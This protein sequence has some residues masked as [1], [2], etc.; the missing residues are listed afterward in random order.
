[1]TTNLGIFYYTIHRSGPGAFGWTACTEADSGNIN[2]CGTGNIIHC[3]QCSHSLPYRWTGRYLPDIGLYDTA[4]ISTMKQHFQWM[5]D[6]G[7]GFV[8]FSWWGKNSISDTALNTLISAIPGFNLEFCIYYENE[9][10]GNP[11]INADI[12]YLSNKCFNNSQ[13]LKVDVNGTKKPVVWVYNQPLASDAQR[14]IATRNS[15]NIY[16]VLKEVPNWQT[17]TGIDAWHQYAPAS[18]YGITK[19]TANK[20]SSFVSPGFYRYHACQR[21]AR[22]DL[23]NSWQDFE[24]ALLTMKND[25]AQWHTIQTFNEWMECSGVEP[26]SYY[27]HT[28][29]G[30]FPK[31]NN[32][33]GTKYLDLI[34]KYFASPVPQKKFNMFN[35]SQTQNNII[36]KGITI[37]QDDSGNL[38][39]NQACIDACTRLGQIS[40]LSKFDILNTSQGSSNKGVTVIQ[41]DNG[42]FTKDQACTQVCNK[43]GQI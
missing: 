36:N 8:I 16:V 7:I 40:I 10:Y 33:Y 18:R 42:Q 38:T 17:V 6:A 9:A 19:T 41:N 37:L 12:D 11:D 21:L 4:D 3:N 29:S 22:C 30:P 35:I 5:Q 14:W 34:A 43:L 20:Y 27:N 31:V 28:L 1:M 26:A 25:G 24:N 2:A 15:K 32:S 13:Y 23:N 39:K